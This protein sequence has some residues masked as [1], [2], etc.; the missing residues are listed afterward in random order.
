MVKSF[1]KALAL[2]LLLPAL[3]SAQVTDAFTRAD[4]GLGTS[5][6]T[7]INALTISSNAATDTTT[8][9]YHGAFYNAA[10]FNPDQWAQV[11]IPVTTNPYMGPGVRM[12]STGGGQGYMALVDPGTSSLFIQKFSGGA[13]VSDVAACTGVSFS[14]GDRLLLKAVGTTLT[15]LIN[16]NSVSCS[17]PDATYSSGQ[18]GMGTF[19]NGP[20]GA[21]NRTM[22][23]W[24]AGNL[25]GSMRRVWRRR[26]G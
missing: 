18:P 12:S 4:G 9:A 1:S 21:S 25:N 19:S 20:A 11:T 16:G 15:A 13:Y 24:A 14:A 6:T 22:D 5:W 10:V 26:R 3:A 17:G 23:D 7:I 8:D 2:V